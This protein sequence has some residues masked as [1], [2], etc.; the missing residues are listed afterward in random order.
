M[1]STAIYP[2]S[3]DP[4]TL[5]HIDLIERDTL[6]QSVQ[7]QR[8]AHETFQAIQQVIPKFRGIIH[9]PDTKHA[10]KQLGD[11]LRLKLVEGLSEWVIGRTNCH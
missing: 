9:H 3:F 2:G 1:G 7:S 11:L 5:G 4:V 6:R 10:T 8:H